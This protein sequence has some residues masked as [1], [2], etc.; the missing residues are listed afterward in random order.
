MVRAEWD[1]VR[2]HVSKVTEAELHRA[3]EDFRR[4][5]V[6]YRNDAGAGWESASKFLTEPLGPYL[7]PDDLI[8]LI[9][10]RILHSFPIHALP[11]GGQPLLVHHPV[12]YAPSCGLLPLLQSPAKGTG[13]L[14]SCAAFGVTYEAEA[15]AVAAVFGSTPMPASS[16]SPES[17]AQLT[18]GADVLHLSCHAYFNRLDPLDSGVYLR[19]GNMPDYP[20]PSDMLTARQIMQI[21]VPS[22]MVTI[23]ACDTGAHEAFAGDELVGLTRAFFYAGTPSIVASLWPVDADATR[24]FMVRFYTSLQETYTRNGVIDKAEA[25]RQAQLEVMSDHA[26]MSYRWAPFILV[27]DWS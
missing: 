26:R 27:G 13:H 6:Q 12:S 8:M 11:L 22:E 18:A 7:G 1:S 15:E 17:L 25:L 20:N 4:Q 9:P 14:S 10:H 19:P 24:D 16:L 21:R 2:V 23:S 3:Y 5:V